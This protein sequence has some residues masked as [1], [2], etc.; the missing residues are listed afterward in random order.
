M[1]GTML[2]FSPEGPRT[3]DDRA[4][5]A[6]YTGGGDGRYTFATLALANGTEIA[7]AI[8]QKRTDKWLFQLLGLGALA[9]RALTALLSRRASKLS[10]RR[11]TKR[12]A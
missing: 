12:V 8:D 6:V 9:K 7:G 10:P 4:V 11:A 2:I 1:N 3:I 5:I